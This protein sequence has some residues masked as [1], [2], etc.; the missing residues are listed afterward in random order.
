MKEFT[1]LTDIEEIKIM[2]DI[3]YHTA[4]NPEERLKIE[5]KE[6][7]MRSV[8]AM[9][10]KEKNKLLKELNEKDQALNEKDQELNEKDQI[11]ADLLKKLEGK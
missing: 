10:E 1:H 4:T 6:E 7:A 5:I 3:L 8:N 11:I 2:T 9:F